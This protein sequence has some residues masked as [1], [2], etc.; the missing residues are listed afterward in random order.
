MPRE[1]RQVFRLKFKALVLAM[2]PVAAA[3]EQ[4]NLLGMPGLLDTP[5][6]RVLGDGELAFHGNGFAGQIRNGVT[7]Q[8]TPALTL[9]FRYARVPL[10]GADR[11]LF[12]RSL[13][14][15]LRLLPEGEWTPALAV[16]LTDFLGTGVFQSEYL[17]ASKRLGPRVDLS[18]GL[19]WGRLGSYGGFENPLAALDPDLAE[20]P[21]RD[22]GL[23]GE[24]EVGAAFQGDAAVFGGVQWQATDRLSLTAEY[25][26]D[27]YDYERAGGYDW[28]APYN[29]GLTWSPTDSFFARAFVAHGENV[30]LQLAW[31]VDPKRH[32][33]GVVVNNPPPPVRAAGQ[34]AGPF[35]GSAL[36]STSLAAMAGAQL[37]AQGMT[38]HGFSVEGAVARIEVENRDHLAFSR[39]AGRAGRVLSR[40]L[41]DGVTVFRVVFVEAGMP[42]SEVVMTRAALEA[43]EFAP[44]A[45][46]A[47]EGATQVIRARGPLA[48]RRGLYPR[49]DY[50]LAP[51]VVPQLFDPDQPLAADA[52]VEVSA[53][54]RPAPGLLFSGS[55]RQ[56]LLGNLEETERTSNS[57]LPRV[58]SDANL[59]AAAADTTIPRLTAAGYA[60]VGRDVY[61]RVT[62]GLLEPMFGGVSGELLWKP[63]DAR[64]ALGAEANWVRQ[65]DFDQ[66]WGFQEYE[67]ATGHVSAYWQ[68]TETLHGQIDAGRY[69]AGDWGAT[70]SLEREFASGWKVGAFA[71]F[72]DVSFEDFG[73]GSFD[74][75]LLFT[76]P[77]GAASGETSRDTVPVA[78]RSLM[79]DGGARL[80]VEGRLYDVVR[81]G[82]GAEIDRDW[83]AF[84]Q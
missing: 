77:L 3:A 80:D 13:S 81:P 10:E 5:S 2:M 73:E 76:I 20:R 42:L 47:M 82:L 49:F 63:F 36:R 16:G 24:V 12:D 30:G 23:G 40:V 38:L 11:D 53:S 56:R 14:A 78:L 44:E 70:F 8:A 71:T 74:K 46:A 79:R 62:A 35:F 59:Y 33:H 34:P 7:F 32:P 9:G 83:G 55:L 67:T 43:Y 37:D 1:V 65:R 45:S 28:A 68:F 48:P 60:R 51:Y 41:P 26:S 31:I 15:H 72:T 6:A 52:G 75:G 69:L 21:G 84:W 64:W 4:V 17:V 58:R 39:A 50:D 25:S 19:G 66:L 61:G 18:L 29:L 54:L 27:A 57:V 22:A